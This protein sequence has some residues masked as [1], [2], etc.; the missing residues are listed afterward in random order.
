MKFYSD[1]NCNQCD[2]QMTVDDERNY[3]LLCYQ[4]CSYAWRSYELA[5]GGVCND[6]INKRHVTKEMKRLIIGRD[7]SA[8]LKCGST[9]NLNVDHITPL[10]RGGDNGYDNLQTLCSSCNSKK[11]MG[12]ADY[13]ESF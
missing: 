9:K 5:H 1:F 7:N 3:K 2:K 6:D 11:G 4:C 12:I 10:S 13:R 8:C